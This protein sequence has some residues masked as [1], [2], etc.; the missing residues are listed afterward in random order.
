MLSTSNYLP[1][2]GQAVSAVTALG[3]RAVRLQLAAPFL[4]GED[5][6]VPA[7][8]DLAGNSSANQSLLPLF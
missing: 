6:L 8:R 7:V 1:G 3:E 2:G 5:L 4:D